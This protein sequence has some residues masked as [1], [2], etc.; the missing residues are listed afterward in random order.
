MSI[1]LLIVVGVVLLALALGVDLVAVIA[2][3]R[4][5]QS[6]VTTKRGSR[7]RHRIT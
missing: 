2:W 4:R 6:A 5:W 3:V 7:R 1:M